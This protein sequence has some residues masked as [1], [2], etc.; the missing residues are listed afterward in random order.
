MTKIYAQAVKDLR[1]PRD[2]MRWAVS[3]FHRAE[4]YFGH[5]TDNAWDEARYLVTHTLSL[6]WNVDDTWLDTR[7]LKSERKQL[8]Q[9]L[10]RRIEKRMPT[11]YLTGEAWFFGLPFKV[12]HR[13]LIPRSP[14]AELIENSFS[15]WLQVEPNRILD[16]C[17]GSGCIGIAC[18]Y[19]YPEAEIVLG[20]LSE[21]AIDVAQSNVQMHGLE[22][23]VRVIQSDLF[24]NI[25]GRFDLIVS[26]PPYV[27]AEDMASLPPEYKHEPQMALEAGDDGLDL[28]RRI[29]KE[30]PHYLNDDGLLVVEV[31]NSWVNIEAA[32]PNVPFTWIEFE[33]GGH[34]VFV[35]TRSE[36]ETVAAEFQ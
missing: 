34:G 31:G 9:Q 36:L 8:A 33:R 24:N 17:C 5:G 13:V 32:F 2:F 19:R 35:L 6:P 4:V 3:Q 15:P 30:A 7:L 28:V 27:D 18:A 10:E 1:T 11:A 29:L 12:D 16:L 23:Q 14:I 25:Q 21:D 26:N 20:E 22:E